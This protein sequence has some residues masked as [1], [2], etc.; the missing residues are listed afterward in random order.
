MQIVY[1]DNKTNRMKAV[2]DPRG[3]G[4][5]KVVDVKENLD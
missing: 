5:G 4:K 2:S 1:W 3:Y